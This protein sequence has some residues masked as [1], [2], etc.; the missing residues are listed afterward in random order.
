MPSHP[1]T[2]G[3]SQFTANELGETR[4]AERQPRDPTRFGNAT[5]KTPHSGATTPPMRH[6]T[7]FGGTRMPRMPDLPA[8]SVLYRRMGNVPERALGDWEEK[9]WSRR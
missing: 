2:R 7:H 1:A 4:R 3:M 5:Q 9:I 8:E 6:P